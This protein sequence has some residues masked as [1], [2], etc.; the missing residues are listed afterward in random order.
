MARHP[1]EMLTQEEVT[2]AVAAARATGRLGEGARF[3]S[4]S[5]EEPPKEA[6]LAG[7]PVDR[8]VH[9]TIVPGPEATLIE[10]A[11]DMATGA[12]VQWAEV[13]GMR[14]ASLFED[15][16]RAIGAL[17]EDPS[18]QAAMKARDI[19][20]FDQVQID[21]WPSGNFGIALE[22]GRRTFRCISYYRE[23]PGS[24]G[25]ARPIEGVLAFVDGGRGEVLDV[26][27]EGVVPLPPELGSYWP[28]DNQPP[29]EGLKPLAI[30][31][32]EGPS[33]TVDGNLVQWQ[34]WSLRV[35]MDPLEGLVLHTVAYDGRPVLYRASICEM[36]VPYGD[37]GPMHGWKNAFDAGEW[38]LGRMANSL[39]L[40]CDC[41]GEIHYFDA[42]FASEGGIAYTL[43]NAICMHEEDYGILWKHQDLNSGRTEVRRSRRLVVSFIA[44]VGN[45]EYGFYW[46][47]Y[48]DGT[49][50]LEVK[51]TGV[52]QTQ[53]LPPGERS[54]YAAPIAPGLHAPVH[55]HLFCARLDFDI[56]GTDNEVYEVEAE[57]V[58]LGDGNPL[59]NAFVARAT[60]LET[61]QA[62]Q[63]C[64]DPSRSRHWRIVNP[65]SRNRLGEPVAYKLVPGA[66]PTLLASPSSS[67]GK[68]AT[69]ATRNLWVTPYR[70][71]ERRAAGDYPNQH[72]GGD[73]LPRWTAAD[74]PIA[75]T[76]VVVWHTFGV[77][78]LPRPEDWPVMPVEY[79]GFHLIPVGFFERNPALDVPAVDHCH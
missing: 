60:L 75:G 52:M 67:V 53:A 13:D 9:L 72:A 36:V 7:A 50:Q 64:I 55:Q 71:D 69:F 56:D 57:P 33:F 17:K 27:D 25:Y 62:A 16:I 41:L 29:R 58:A 14:P 23:Q 74:R 46:Y 68:R 34:R 38:G 8:R 63:R 51:L 44:T 12:V 11:V 66:A 76:D 48:L 39:V 19:T 40:G 6:V 10:A 15:A 65:H 79:C 2:T 77:T 59:S 35:S 21:P 4:V 32:P 70:A 42:V 30:T 49:V 24:N 43:Q 18:W 37:P 1:L 61:E 5:L 47:F 20:D 45:Y 26:I 73:G 22:E 54:P 3:A 28:E 78:H 31:Q